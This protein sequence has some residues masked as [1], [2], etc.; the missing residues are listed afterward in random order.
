VTW[1]KIPP[2]AGQASLRLLAHVRF[3]LAIQFLFT[4]I[5][6]EMERSPWSITHPGAMPLACWETVAQAALP[7]FPT[8]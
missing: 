2:C 5:N 8:N 3:G 7:D 6:G 1:C 4:H